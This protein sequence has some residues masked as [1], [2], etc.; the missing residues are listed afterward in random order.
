MSKS[1]AALK[2]PVSIGVDMSILAKR[3]L[4]SLGCLIVWMGFLFFGGALVKYVVSGLAGWFV[5][6]LIYDF[7]KKLFP[8]DCN[9]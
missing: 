3:I 4:F 6:R 9:E 2:R 5:G 1:R 8:D 7:S